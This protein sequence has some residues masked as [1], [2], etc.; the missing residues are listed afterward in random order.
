MKHHRLLVLSHALLSWFPS[1]SLL[2]LEFP[3]RL[4]RSPKSL[5]A[6]T[7]G[8]GGSGVVGLLLKHWS[9]SL[10][11]RRFGSRIITNFVL[12]WFT[13]FDF[14]FLLQYFWVNRWLDPHYWNQLDLGQFPFCMFYSQGRVKLGFF[15]DVS[16]DWLLTVV[17]CINLWIM[18]VL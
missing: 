1:L 15:F 13:C 8:S 9:L 6:M 5:Q 3:L 14:G 12:I 17:F 11:F 7:M 4:L 16:V 2:D 18:R 10:Y